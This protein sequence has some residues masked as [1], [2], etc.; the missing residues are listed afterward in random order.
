[1]SYQFDVEEQTECTGWADLLSSDPRW[2]HRLRPIAPVQLALEWSPCPLAEQLLGTPFSQSVETDGFPGRCVAMVWHRRQ[3]ERIQR[4]SHASSSP[5]ERRFVELLGDA[6]LLA[7]MHR[8]GVL[9]VAKPGWSYTHAR[10]MKPDIA[11][12]MIRCGYV[13]TDRHP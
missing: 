7:R 1:M 4:L 10:P 13:Q 6:V 8:C 3:L 12:S 11:Q 9:L 2:R 5:D